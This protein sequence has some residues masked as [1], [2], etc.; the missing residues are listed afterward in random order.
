MPTLA[1]GKLPRPFFVFALEFVGA[2]EQHRRDVA[3]E[4]PSALAG[5][6]DSRSGARDD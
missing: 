4:R 2:R 3:I 1:L 6:F 5:V